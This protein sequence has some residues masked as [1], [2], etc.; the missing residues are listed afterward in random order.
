MLNAIPILGWIISLLVNTSLSIP[1]WI[2]W[3]RFGVGQKYFS[4]L[5][6]VWQSIPFWDCIALFVSVSV[7]QAVFVPKIVSLN[8]KVEKS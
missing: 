6:E 3:T 8:Q 4:F 5:P 7:I 2:F 1:F